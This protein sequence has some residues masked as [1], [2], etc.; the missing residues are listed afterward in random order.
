MSKVKNHTIELQFGHTDP[1]GKVHTTVTFGKRLTGGDMMTLDSDPQAQIPTQYNDLMQRKMITKFGTLKVPVAL[2][3]LLGLN[4]IDR[5]DLGL[6]M[7]TFLE[8]SADG[9][10]AEHRENNVVKLRYGFAFDGA[11]YDV[12]HLD[13]MTT[14]FDEVAADGMHLTGISREC[15][16][17]GRMISKISSD[18]GLAAIDGPVDLDKFK[19]LDAADISLLRT[20]A[21]LVELGFRLKGKDFSGEWSGENGVLADANDGNERSGDPESSDSPAE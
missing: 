1:T 20:G 16:L 4:K 21:R 15:Y 13:N 10:L 2:N 19:D 9:R 12:V 8:V 5:E 3:V 6:A 18:E 17:V 7:S 11:N 14:G